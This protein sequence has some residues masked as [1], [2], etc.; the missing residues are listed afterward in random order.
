MHVDE[1]RA[2]NDKGILY[3]TVGGRL[4]ANTSPEL[5]RRLSQA[6]A[7]GDVRILLDFEPLEYISSAGLRVVLKTAREL[8]GTSGQLVLCCLRDYIREV[9]ELAG[10]TTIINVA[11]NSDEALGQF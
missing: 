1:A 8:E 9:F 2:G 11:E 10:F 3:L 7:G 4:D 6:M 5:E